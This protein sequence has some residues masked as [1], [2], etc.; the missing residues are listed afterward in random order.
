MI[1][2]FLPKQWTHSNMRCLGKA[3]KKAHHQLEKG[4]KDER[5]TP[6]IYAKPSLLWPV[7]QAHGMDRPSSLDII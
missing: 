7:Q 5:F 1:I 3:M 4:T 6:I 2:T